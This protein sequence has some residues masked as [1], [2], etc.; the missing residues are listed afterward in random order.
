[1]LPFHFFPNPSLDLAEEACEEKI[2][3]LWDVFWWWRQQR[4]LQRVLGALLRL[5]EWGYPP[6]PAPDRGRGWGAQPLC[7]LQL[8]WEEGRAAGSAEPAKEP[9]NAEVGWEAR[10]LQI[11]PDTD[12]LSSMGQARE[13]PGWLRCGLCLPEN[14]NIG[15]TLHNLLGLGNIWFTM[16]QIC[17]VG[18]LRKLRTVCG[19][20]KT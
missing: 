13:R 20:G 11:E 5:P 2:R 17:L 15:Q 19:L 10:F 18:V 14:L 1:M 12:A 6:L 8:G 7:Q 4:R 16:A 9:E 3:A